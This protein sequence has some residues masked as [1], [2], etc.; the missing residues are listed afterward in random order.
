ML[1]LF[2]TRFNVK[3]AA[4]VSVREF[5]PLREPLQGFGDKISVSKTP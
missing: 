2:V 5:R 4:D 1:R 3:S